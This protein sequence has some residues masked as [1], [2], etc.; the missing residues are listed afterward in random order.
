MTPLSVVII[1][2]NEAD[3]IALAI[4]SVPF[5]A[6]YVVVDGGSTDR[7]VKV[8]QTLGARVLHRPFDD[9]SRQKQFALEQAL[10]PWILLLDADEVVSPELAQEIQAALQAAPEKIGGYALRRTN[11]YRGKRMKYGGWGTQRI[12]RLFRKESAHMDGAPVHERVEVEGNVVSLQGPLLHAPYRDMTDHLRACERYARLKA[13]P[14][15]QVT[16]LELVFLPLWRFF[17]RYCLSRG[18]LEGRE[19]LL[20]CLLGAWTVFLRLAFLQENSHSPGLTPLSSP[21]DPPCAS[22]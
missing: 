8:C 9:F 5:A 16:T 20:V 2:Q 17:H 1:A 11:F 14:P 7:T 4:Q 10:Q 22:P 3:R 15:R 12:V 6:E 18:F 21:K 19:G 13:G